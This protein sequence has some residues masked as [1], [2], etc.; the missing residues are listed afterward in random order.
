[1]EIFDEYFLFLKQL[2]IFGVPNYKCNIWA[3]NI[4]SICFALNSII[5]TKVFPSTGALHKNTC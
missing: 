5:E 2:Y 1:M 3:I 4:M